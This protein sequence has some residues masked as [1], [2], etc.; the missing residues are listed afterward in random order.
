MLEA[1]DPAIASMLS[2]CSPGP[3]ASLSGWSQADGECPQS[4]HRRAAGV[5]CRRASSPTSA[6][7]AARQSVDEW[8]AGAGF[9]GFAVVAFEYYIKYTYFLFI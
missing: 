4:K 6:C 9:L 5:C 3:A 8:C 7:A 2:R 1:D